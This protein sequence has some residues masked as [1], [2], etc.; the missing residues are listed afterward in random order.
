MFW[1]EGKLECEIP[2]PIVD[3]RPLIVAHPAA[4]INYLAAWNVMIEHGQPFVLICDDVN[5]HY[6]DEFPFHIDFGNS[7]YFVRMVDSSSGDRVYRNPNLAF[8]NLLVHREIDAI[9]GLDNLPLVDILF[10]DWLDA[11]HN[12]P[13]PSSFAKVAPLMAASVR[14]GGIVILDKKH[15]KVVPNWFDFPQEVTELKYIGTAEWPIL[16]LD[17]ISGNEIKAE[18]FTVDNSSE[19]KGIFDFLSTLVIERRMNKYDLQIMKT[20]IPRRNDSTPGKDEWMERYLEGLDEHGPSPIPWPMPQVSPWKINY[21]KKWIQELIDQPENQR[22]VNRKVRTEV[23]GN[24]KVHFINDNILNHVEWLYLRNASLVLRKIL[25]SE[26]LKVCPLLKF[27]AVNLQPKWD[28]P[29]IPKLQWSGQEATPNLTTEI[30]KHADGEMV[31]TIAHG[32][33]TFQALLIEMMNYQGP[34]QNLIIFH[35]DE[36]DYSNIIGKGC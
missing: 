34:V 5:P 23:I 11:I 36:L 31:A 26:C 14:D 1:K 20:R 32:D 17:I 6:P 25:L 30:L 29:L 28:A 2:L 21:Y 22:P 19:Q 15:E 27:R 35:L 12:Q 18:L 13:S 9:E 10:I 33:A 3:G 4:G 24:T 7:E 16:D 8:D